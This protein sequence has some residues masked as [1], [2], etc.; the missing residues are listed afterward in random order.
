MQANGR[1]FEI[2]GH[3]DFD[4]RFESGRRGCFRFSLPY[5][6]QEFVPVCCCVCRAFRCGGGYR[7]GDFRED[8]AEE[9]PN[10]GR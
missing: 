8:M 4:E 7:A 9:C 2:S 1:E 6:L 10:R 5:S 3:G